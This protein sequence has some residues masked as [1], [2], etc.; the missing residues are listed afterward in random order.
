MV[1][2]NDDLRE[3]FYYVVD[4]FGQSFTPQDISA[5]FEKG[6]IG[7]YFP[8]YWIENIVQEGWLAGFI[9]KTERVCKLTPRGKARAHII[10]PNLIVKYNK[11]L[12]ESW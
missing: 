10:D 6:S 9:E 8:L 12:M 2:T 5:K 1:M 7:K 3:I 11:M 4:T